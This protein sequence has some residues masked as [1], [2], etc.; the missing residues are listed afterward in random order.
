MIEGQVE[1]N[2]DLGDGEVLNLS[3]YHVA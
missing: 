2:D 3:I 1:E